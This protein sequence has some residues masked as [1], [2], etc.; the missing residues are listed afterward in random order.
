MGSTFGPCTKDLSRSLIFF[1]GWVKNQLNWI[2]VNVWSNVPNFIEK[3]GSRIL[4]EKCVHWIIHLQFSN[5]TDFSLGHSKKFSK[6]MNGSDL[7]YGARK[8]AP[9]TDLCTVGANV[10]Q[11]WSVLIAR[12]Y[13][14][15]FKF[16]Q[17]F[18][19]A[20]LFEQNSNHFCYKLTVQIWTESGSNSF[21]SP[22]SWRVGSVQNMN[23]KNRLL[24]SSRKKKN[25]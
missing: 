12:L 3:V 18:L 15:L 7:L 9:Q 1:S 17:N 14:Q 24:P 20:R 11:M 8:W 6:L 13:N 23:L 10:V 4:I 25:K 5:W 2:A 22:C 19:S 16:A 21:K